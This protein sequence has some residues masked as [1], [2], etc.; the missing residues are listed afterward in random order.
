MCKARDYLIRLITIKTGTR[1]GV[2][3]TVTLQHYNTMKRD[4]ETDKLVLLVPDHKRGV[5]GP[6]LIGLDNKLEEFFKIYVQKIGPK[7]GDGC[8]NLFVTSKGLAFTKGTLCTRLPELWSRLGVRSDLRV[9]A[10]NIRKWIVTTC[11]EKKTRGVKFDKDI[12]RQG[13]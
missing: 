6:A 13:L 4:D 8:A 10:T 7:F 9:T 11:H 2:L 1:P 3:E 5:V 12:V